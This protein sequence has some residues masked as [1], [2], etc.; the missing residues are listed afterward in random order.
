MSN[1]LN[2]IED[3]AKIELDHRISKHI[4]EMPDEIKGRFKAIKI[5]QDELVDLEEEQ[6]KGVRKNEVMFE[7]IYEEVYTQRRDVLMNKMPEDMF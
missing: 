3:P 6:T 5:M 2:G 4:S 7:K 1:T